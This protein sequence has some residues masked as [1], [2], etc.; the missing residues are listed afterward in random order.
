MPLDP[1]KL[2]PNLVVALHA[3]KGDPGLFEFDMDDKINS[4]DQPFFVGGKEVAIKVPVQ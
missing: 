4:V 2:T 3:D 1:V